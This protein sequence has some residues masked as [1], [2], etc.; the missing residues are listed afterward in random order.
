M[1]LINLLEDEL[2]KLNNLKKRTDKSGYYS[3]CIMFH[4]TQQVQDVYQVRKVTEETANKYLGDISYKRYENTLHYIEAKKGSV[5]NNINKASIDYMYTYTNSFGTREFTQPYGLKYC[6]LYS[7]NYDK[8]AFV[9]KDKIYL[10]GNANLFLKE[11]RATI[12][13]AIQRYKSL[14]DFHSAWYTKEHD[15]YIGPGVTGG[16]THSNATYET[17]TVFVDIEEFCKI[18]NI[19]YTPKEYKVTNVQPIIHNNIMD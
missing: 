18:H 12:K 1:M 3:E 16:I 14:Q 11:V 5:W 4:I 19:S 6:W 7:K 17:F 9:F 8:L 10:I 2:Q 13:E 15:F